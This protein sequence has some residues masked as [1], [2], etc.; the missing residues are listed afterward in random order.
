MCLTIIQTNPDAAV[1]TQELAKE[2]EARVH[3]VEPSGVFEVVVVMLERGAGVVRRID[4]DALHLSG[5]ERQQRL[6]RL[7]VVAVDED[8]VL[9]RFSIAKRL[10][11]AE[12]LHYDVLRRLDRFLAPHPV[13]HRHV[14]AS[15]RKQCPRNQGDK[16]HVWFH[17]PFY[18]FRF[19]CTDGEYSTISSRSQPNVSQIRLRI[20]VVTS[21]PLESFASVQVDRPTA[22]RISVRVMPRSISSFQSRLYENAIRKILLEEYGVYYIKFPAEQSNPKFEKSDQQIEHSVI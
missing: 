17:V 12:N 4:V 22:R 19:G 7:Q 15:L 16:Q 13:Q 1:L 9:G 18:A 11:L 14:R 6:Q 8:V 2:L 3:H 10:L 5:I 20:V 21:S